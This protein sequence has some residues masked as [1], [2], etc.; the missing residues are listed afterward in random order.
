MR[1]TSIVANLIAVSLARDLKKITDKV[2]FDVEINGETEGR[3]TFGLYGD[4]VPLTVANF[5]ALSEGTAGKGTEGEDLDYFG[6]PFHR[7]IPSFMAQGG[8][9]TAGDGTGGES[10]YGH[11]FDDENFLITH[12]KPYMLSMANSGPNTNGS[13][14]FITFEATPWL[15]GH[16]VAFGEVLNGFE[17]VDVLEANGTSSGTPKKRATI[18]GCGVVKK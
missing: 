4:T 12:S 2:Y 5:V 18:S 15:D 1:I 11:N 17:V 13:Q 9:I 14:F 3:I 7:I 8:D 16:H 6:S 10:I